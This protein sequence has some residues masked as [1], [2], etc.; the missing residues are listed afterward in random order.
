VYE[1]HSFRSAK[2]KAEQRFTEVSIGI[3][4]RK[5][6]QPD[7]LWRWETVEIDHPKARDIEIR[8]KIVIKKNGDKWFY[9]AMIRGDYALFLRSI[10]PMDLD[11]VL[12][13]FV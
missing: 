9:Y 7:E 8:H 3:F 12:D 4:A 6:V 1:I 5:R 11:S 13:C 10:A 2:A